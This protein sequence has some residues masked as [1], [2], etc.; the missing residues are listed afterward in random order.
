MSPE[1]SDPEFYTFCVL[2]VCFVII[3][4]IEGRGNLKLVFLVCLVA[5]ISSTDVSAGDKKY[6]SRGAGQSKR[7]SQT[8][9]E[10]QTYMHWLQQGCPSFIAPRYNL[11]REPSGQQQQRQLPSWGRDGVGS[12]TK[13]R[14]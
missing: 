5:L 3:S 7:P 2:L 6:T 8:V 9:V 12:T 11:Q 10:Q 14:R 13:G 1:M 4:L